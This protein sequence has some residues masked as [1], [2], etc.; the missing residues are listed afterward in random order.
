ME[1]DPNMTMENGPLNFHGKKSHY[2]SIQK[3]GPL[4]FHGKRP[5]KFPWKKK[6]P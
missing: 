4:N 6:G 1:T 2:I 5:L 3:G